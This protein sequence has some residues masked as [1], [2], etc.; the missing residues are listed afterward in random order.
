M[1]GGRPAPTGR[2]DAGDRR[3]ARHLGRHRAAPRKLRPRQAW[4]THA[5]GAARAARRAVAPRSRLLGVLDEDV[6]DTVRRRLT[7][8]HRVLERFVDRLPADDDRRLDLVVLEEACARRARD[9]VGAILDLLDPPDF[10]GAPAEAS[11]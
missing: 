4:G 8:V 5:R 1:G 11:S 10:L 9:A 3:A 7:R 2:L 6:A